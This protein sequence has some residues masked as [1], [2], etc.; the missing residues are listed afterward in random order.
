MVVCIGL[1]ARLWLFTSPPDGSHE[2]RQTQTLM[3][4]ASYAHG[5]PWL[6]PWVTWYGARPRPGVLELPVYS[7]LAY[8]LSRPW[9]LL[10]GARIVSLA[11]GVASI[12]V[13]DGICKL[14]RHPRRRLA[15]ALFILSPSAIWASHATQPDG[16]LLLLTL[17]SVYCFLRAESRRFFWLCAAT[18]ALVSASL[19][20]P[21]AIITLTP[22]LL[23]V[24][25]RTGRLVSATVAI[26]LTACAVGLWALHDRALL[27]SA[28]PDWYMANTRW[29]KAPLRS[30]FDPGLYGNLSR[31]LLLVLLPP[32][33][34][35]LL[36]L[37]VL[38]K[39]V[40][41]RIDVFWWLWLGGG[42]ASVIV[43][44]ELNNVH[45]YYQLLFIPALA[46]VVAYAFPAWTSRKGIAGLAMVVAVLGGPVSARILDAGDPTRYDA[47]VALGRSS[48]ASR[49][50]VVLSLQGSAPW[51]PTVLYYADRNGWNLPLDVTTE[52]LSA[53]PQPVPCVM[54]IVRDGPFKGVPQNWEAKTETASYIIARRLSADCG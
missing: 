7:I 20:K 36:L 39:S 3:Y 2:W 50:V 9:G 31:R 45:H 10:I 33:A 41:T 27:L 46:A 29:F 11:C 14:R 53:L 47:G 16:L 38:R 1:V 44:S 52:R 54:V 25:W 30:V 8:L 42:A 24:A 40:R 4:A 15:T 17:T 6:A 51:Y 48:D 35:I 18:V 21:T 19:I 26:A 22:V 34:I 43:F 28:A 5:A 23:Y 37:G 12:V 49:P 13:F 32:F